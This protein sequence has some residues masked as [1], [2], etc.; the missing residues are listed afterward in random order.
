MAGKSRFVISES[1]IKNFFLKRGNVFAEDELKKILEER[2]TIWNLPI[3]MSPQKFIDKLQ[4]RE[5]LKKHEIFFSGYYPNKTRYISKNASVFDLTL[6]L[7]PRAYLSHYSAAFFLGLTTQVPKT[8]YLT[9]EQ[10]QKKRDFNVKLNQKDIDSAFKKPQRKSGV[11]G[12]Y[13][14]YSIIFHNGMFTNK[15]GV[16]T[17][18]G[19]SYTNLERTLIDITVRPE[20]G[21]GVSRVLDIYKNSISALSINK[22]KATLQK[23]NFIYPYHQAIGFYLERAGLDEKRLS[24]LHAFEK[25][26]DFYLTYDMKEMDYDKNW[27]IY[28]PKGI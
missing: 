4:E 5:I 1:S 8:I 7:A 25:V 23:L 13:E 3:S 22:L 9:S 17:K 6:S 28:F 11:I 21:G 16:F 24:E 27:K 14:E 12:I 10:S 18:N 2:R 20:Y 26:N 19:I 15:L